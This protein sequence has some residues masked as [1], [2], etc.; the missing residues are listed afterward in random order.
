MKPG[1]VWVTLWSDRVALF[2]DLHGESYHRDLW[3]GEVTTVVA[4]RE[5]KAK[6]NMRYD[7]VQLLTT[8]GLWWAAEETAKGNMHRAER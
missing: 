6:N 8:D 4:R 3:T 5:M 7:M 1:Q 2:H